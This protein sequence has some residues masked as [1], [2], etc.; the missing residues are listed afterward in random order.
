VASAD[1]ANFGVTSSAGS[2]SALSNL[3]L[4]IGLQPKH[5]QNFDASRFTLPTIYRHA[6]HAGYTTTLI[7]AQMSNGQLHNDMS[8]KDLKDID[9]YLTA[10]RG[11][12]VF[13]RDRFMIDAIKTRLGRAEKHFVVLVKWGA[14]WPYQY[15]Y[16][17][18]E[19]FFTPTVATVMGSM[20]LENKDKVI[21]TY[22]NA[23]RYAADGFL[24]KLLEAVELEDRMVIYTSDHGQTLLEN[25]SVRTHGDASSTSNGQGSVPLLLFSKNVKRLFPDLHLHEYSSFQIFTTTLKFFGYSDLYIA[26]YGPTLFSVPGHE[27]RA[28]FI[29]SGGRMQEYHF[30][31]EDQAPVLQRMR[32]RP[33]E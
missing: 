11:M 5:G 7:D 25:A 1:V 31:P 19:E 20:T 6:K 13:H 27:Y 10:D 18:T 24:R 22:L 8:I 12:D 21:N 2:H 28:F 14:H 29:T 4:R 3:A 33:T 15:T 17:K 26:N 30:E 16:P 32:S 9:E 23:V